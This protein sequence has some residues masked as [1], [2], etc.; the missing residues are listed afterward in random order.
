MIEWDWSPQQDGHGGWFFD[1]P[2]G[3]QYAGLT[4]DLTL[5]KSRKAQKEWDRIQRRMDKFVL[6]YAQ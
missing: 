6:E 4:Y 3:Q 2:T 1:L 5:A